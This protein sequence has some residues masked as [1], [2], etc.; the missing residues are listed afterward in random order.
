M[1]S[2]GLIAKTVWI[3]AI[4]RKEIYV[5]VLV[6][7]AI[8]LAAGSMRFFGF[9]EMTKFYRE[10]SLQMM[11][12][13]TALTVILLA[14][15]QLPR[16][17]ERRTIYPLLAKPV[18]RAAFLI[19]KFIG[20]LGAGLFCY[21]IFILLFLLGMAWLDASLSWGL[22]L[23]AVYLQVLALSVVASL[24]FL[25]SLLFNVDAAIT[26]STLIFVLGGTVSATI[27]FIHE[28]VSTFIPLGEGLSVGE[29]FMKALNYGIPQMTLFDLSA[30]VVHATDWVMKNGEQ[31][32]V[33]RWAPVE[34]W[35]LGALTL[36]ASFFVL[37]YLLFSYCLFS[38]R[39]L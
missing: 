14:S 28:S 24:S 39:A 23:Q 8:L 13:A 11:N 1:R 16:E 20:V 31:V 33:V 34:S 26:V 21:A 17:F 6:V 3:E 10:I 2:I 27:D 29:I 7:A 36:Y 38:R 25:L 22:F 12:L 32:N 35:V 37:S 9:R 30:K 18:S 5:I 19:G 4:R 15:R